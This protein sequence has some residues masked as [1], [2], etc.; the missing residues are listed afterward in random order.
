VARLQYTV[1][2]WRR[3]VTAGSRGGGRRWYRH[4]IGSANVSEK[5]SV[6]KDLSVLLGGME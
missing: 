1:G 6:W 2:F 4:F 5:E 3:D